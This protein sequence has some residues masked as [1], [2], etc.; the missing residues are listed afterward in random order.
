MGDSYAPPTSVQPSY[1]QPPAYGGQTSYDPS[2][3][4]QPGGQ[5][6]YYQQPSY[7]QPDSGQQGYYQQPAYGQP[8]ALPDPG[9]GQGYYQQP[10]YGQPS[11]GQEYGQGSYGQPSYGQASAGYGQQA[12][13][14]YGGYGPSSGGFPATTEAPKKSNQ[15]LIIAIVVVV[16][17]AALAAVALFVWPGFLNKKVFDEKQV[18]QGVTSVLTG[19]PPSGYGLSGVSDVTCPSGQ[20]VTAGTSFQCDLKLDGTATKVTVVVKDSSGLYEVNPPS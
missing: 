8:G 13:P 5:Q 14:G 10:G 6:G 12:Q 1:G 2:S 19:N 11:G 18:A 16:V 9:A 7:G 17:L 15:G 4:G 3:Y 20:P